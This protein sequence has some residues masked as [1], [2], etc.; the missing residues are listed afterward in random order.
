MV[1]RS[2]HIGENS[3]FHGGKKHIDLNKHFMR[4]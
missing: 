1:S 4:K 3:Y 2:N